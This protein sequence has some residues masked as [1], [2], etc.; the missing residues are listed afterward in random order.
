M[1]DSLGLEHGDYF[2]ARFAEQRKGLGFILVAHSGDLPIGA[3]WAT[4][5]RAHESEG[6]PS[7][8]DI[9]FLYHF[10]VCKE[11]RCQGV[12]T[13]MLQLAERMLY[14]RG[15][16]Q[17]ALGVDQHNLDARRLYERLGYQMRIKGIRTQGVVNNGDHVF[18]DPY[19]ILV[20]DLAAD[21][22]PHDAPGVGAAV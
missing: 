11:Y 16:I 6:E 12:G 22:A 10:E 14:A 18:G 17:V 4:W 21:G 3:V 5:L 2:R 8:A 9:P 19:D 1:R 13:A 7:L 15:F 20:H